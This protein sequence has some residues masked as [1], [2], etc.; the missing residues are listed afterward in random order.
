M[1]ISPFRAALFV[2]TLLLPGA[3]F[4]ATYDVV[5]LG[6]QVIDGTGAPAY[7]A[8]IGLK[9]DRIA[10]IAREGLKAEDGAQA[11]DAKGLV[12]APGFIDH[13]AHIA[14]NIHEYPLA[15]NFTRQGITTIVASLHSG[16]QPYPLKPY[17]DS[18][19]V[20]PN[21]AFFT[22]HSFAR[23]RVLGMQN[24][25][26]TPAELLRMQKI[27]A[28]SMRDG[29]IGLSSGLVYVP[30][31]YAKPE[32]VIALAK[33]AA[34]WG[35]IYVS[36]MRDE[37]AGVLDSV[38]ETIQVAETA[39][40]PGQINHHKVQGATQMGW[41][42]QSLALIDAAR[43]RG[44]DFTLDVYPYTASSTGSSV[45]FPSW[46]LAGGAEAYRARIADPAERKRLEADMLRILMVQRG[47][48][49]LRKL[50]FRRVPSDPAFDGKTLEDMVKARGLKGTPQDAV[51]VIIDLQAK[52]GFTAIYHVM[53]EADVERIIRYPLTMVDSDGDPVGFDDGFPHPRTYGAFP[54]YLGRY[55][56]E[57]K[58]LSLPEAIRRITSMSADQIGQKQRGRIVEGSFADIT[59]FDADRIADTAD[60]ETPH[61]YP[62]GIRH[63]IINGQPVIRAGA[64]TAALPGRALT[65]RPRPDRVRP[66]P[67]T[68][69]CPSA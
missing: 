30:A 51:Q 40:L 26:P 60:F 20:A 31:N 35:G 44:V 65:D 34:C 42:V 38:R 53:D 58:V 36:H 11:L 21:V 1:R 61:A 59:V 14:T 25:A 39:K 41:S 22:G 32:E 64:F 27:V 2:S 29:A 48:A 68:P 13:H 8:D 12:V 54:R 5:I 10:R 66:D 50:Q 23:D 24:R 62:V 69:G 45:M 7:R 37:G 47:G 9:G 57:K 18:L 16:A 3:A 33:V 52:G 28:D 4:A 43:A 63:V 19:R 49:D 56:R 55:V 67:S 17:I 6:G 15:E 46:A